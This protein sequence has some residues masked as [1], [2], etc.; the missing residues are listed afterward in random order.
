MRI[1][2]HQIRLRI[3]HANP[4]QM[5]IELLVAEALGDIELM[6][7]PILRE[8]LLDVVLV[9]AE[10]HKV[11]LGARLADKSAVS[12]VGMRRLPLITVNAVGVEL[13]IGDQRH[14]QCSQLVCL[15]LLEELEASL[16]S[17]LGCCDWRRSVRVRRNRLLLALF[18][19]LQV[20]SRQQL[21]TLESII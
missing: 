21:D 6:R 16:A 11:D 17:R 12:D 4:L 9:H 8:D 15:G 7:V 2:V 14:H 19:L 3:L 13:V 18:L 10:V 20:F 1:L 5:V